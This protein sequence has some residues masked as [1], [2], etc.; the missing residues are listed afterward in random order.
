[1]PYGFYSA[2]K[3]YRKS[4]NSIRSAKRSQIEILPPNCQQRGEVPD[5]TI[6]NY[7]L[8]SDTFEW[9]QISSNT[10]ETKG[11]RNVPISGMDDKRSITATFSITAENKFLPI[12]LIYKG[13]TSQSLPKIQFL[14]GFSLSSNLK[15]YSNT[16]ESLKF[17]NEIILPMKRP[18]KKSWGFKHDHLCLYM[19]SF[20]DKQL[21]SFCM[22]CINIDIATFCHRRYHRT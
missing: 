13:K 1:M 10:M 4:A 7:Q 19:T 16:T 11:A 18:N 12:E 17:H 15:H 2:P 22:S 6:P 20:R 8:R 9:V 14:N 3:D 21:T 5:T